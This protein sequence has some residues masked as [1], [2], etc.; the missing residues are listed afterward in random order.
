VLD[1]ICDDYENVDQVILRHVSELSANCG[2]KIDR[3]EV[4]SALAWLIED[5]LAK[6]YLLSCREPHV[7][8]L[9]GMPPL[10]VPEEYFK[11]YFYCTK[12]G[13]DRSPAIGRQRM[14]LRRRRQTAT[15]LES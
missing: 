14:A 13:M 4:V 7:T 5:G 2:L 11:T 1:A 6:A 8:E 3:A 10:D 9:P 12:R 15:Q